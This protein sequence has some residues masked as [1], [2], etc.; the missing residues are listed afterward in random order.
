MGF[1]SK[2]PLATIDLYMKQGADLNEMIIWTA[3]GS[4]VDFTGATARLPV[5]MECQ[6]DVLGLN[7]TSSI[8]GGIVLGTLAASTLGQIAITI[9]KAATQ[10]LRDVGVRGVHSLYID[11]A[12]GTTSCLFSGKTYIAAGSPF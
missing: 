2:E 7:T 5:V 4:L 6:G 8:Y 9:T 12:D 1:N 10:A 11:W 3:G